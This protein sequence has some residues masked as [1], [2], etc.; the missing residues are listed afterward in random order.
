MWKKNTHLEKLCNRHDL[1]AVFHSLTLIQGGAGQRRGRRSDPCVSFGLDQHAVFGG[2]LEVA[3]NDALH[4]PGGDHAQAQPHSR[5][6]VVL[7]VCDGV[8]ADDPVCELWRGGLMRGEA[9]P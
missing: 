4:L 3:Q 6:F 7:P 9:T 1:S 8:A 2:G 5:L